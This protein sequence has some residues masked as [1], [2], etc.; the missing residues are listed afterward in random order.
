MRTVKNKQSKRS[1]Y[2]LA[3][4]DLMLLEGINEEETEDEYATDDEEENERLL[5]NSFDDV[6][7]ENEIDTLFQ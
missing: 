3:Q 7:G 6:M 1:V 5:H 4:D 2:I